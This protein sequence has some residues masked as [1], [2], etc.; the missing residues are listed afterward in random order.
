MLICFK[1]L[2]AY[3]EE[4]VDDTEKETLGAFWTFIPL[5]VISL[6]PIQTVKSDS[7]GGPFQMRPCGS[8]SLILKKFGTGCP[9]Y[10]LCYKAG[11]IELRI[12]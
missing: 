4:D 11:F 6:S 3:E 5:K 8:L 7:D 2:E 9:S 10:P 1:F 12:S